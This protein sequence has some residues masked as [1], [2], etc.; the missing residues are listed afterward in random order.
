MF[1]APILDLVQF[2]CQKRCWARYADLGR[3]D[4]LWVKSAELHEIGVDDRPF[5]STYDPR[6]AGVMAGQPGRAASLAGADGLRDQ[7]IDR[8]L[9]L[10]T[11]ASH[12]AGDPYANAVLGLREKARI[13]EQP[14]HWGISR[15]L[16]RVDDKVAVGGERGNGHV[17][18]ANSQVDGLGAHQDQ[19]VAVSTESVERIKE[20]TTGKY[21]ELIHA[22]PSRVC[23]STQ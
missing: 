19:G 6:G 2:G 23:S 1:P 16:T 11:H 14:L 4:I 22:N 5:E 20:H 10:P 17:R 12:A 7:K 21:V 18:F 15:E 8:N 3:P 13:P 9:S